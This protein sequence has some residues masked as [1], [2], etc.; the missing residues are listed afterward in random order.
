MS[1]RDLNIFIERF[2]AMNFDEEQQQA[3][4]K[5][6]RRLCSVVEINDDVVYRVEEAYGVE[7]PK[8]VKNILSVA[9]EGLSFISAFDDFRLMSTQEIINAP[10][11]L[12]V[13]FNAIKSIPIFDLGNNIYVVYQ[14]MLDRWGK[15]NAT[16][17]MMG[18]INRSLDSLMVVDD[19]AEKKRKKL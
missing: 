9:P 6:F 12:N 7:L 3:S 8:S 17:G 5:N 13:D 2:K 16:S 15:Y 19:K 11:T 10:Q 18:D 14:Y 4:F 1:K